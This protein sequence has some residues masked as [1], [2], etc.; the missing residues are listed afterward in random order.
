[1]GR[2]WTLAE[3]EDIR[4]FAANLQDLLLLAPADLRPII[5]LD[6]GF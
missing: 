6:L 1:M 5:A 4:V 2:L 3:Q